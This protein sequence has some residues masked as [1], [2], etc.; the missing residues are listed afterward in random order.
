M[1][2]VPVV[3]KPR[4]SEAII[5]HRYETTGDIPVAEY[6]PPSGTLIIMTPQLALADRDVLFTFR[7]KGNFNYNGSQPGW[8]E[9]SFLSADGTFHPWIR[10]FERANDFC[11]NVQVAQWALP[12]SQW[13]LL[14]GE[15]PQPVESLTLGLLRGF[16]NFACW[17]AFMSLTVEWDY[18]IAPGTQENHTWYVIPMTCHKTP[19]T[20]PGQP[21]GVPHYHPGEFTINRRTG[22][23]MIATKSWSVITGDY[24][25]MMTLSG[26]GVAPADADGNQIPTRA[27]PGTFE[28]VT[29][30]R[31]RGRVVRLAVD[32]GCPLE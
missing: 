19:V 20:S 18:E 29:T 14:L 3:N 9:L 13:N 7:A 27:L 31:L 5:G 8:V 1:A 22:K 30:G 4:T 28:S 2:I 16:G 24:E 23:L 11:Q 21:R 25:P 6:D 10:M 12:A 15:F 17:A 32:G 26:M